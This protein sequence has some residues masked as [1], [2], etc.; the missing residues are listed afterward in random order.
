MFSVAFKRVNFSLCSVIGLLA[1]CITYLS[2]SK[3]DSAATGITGE[4]ITFHCC[5]RDSESK[6]QNKKKTRKGPTYSAGVRTK[7]KGAENRNK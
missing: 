4:C 5:L 6:T 2:S 1:K 3:L 7:H